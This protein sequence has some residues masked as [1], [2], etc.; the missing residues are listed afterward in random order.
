MG[1]IFCFLVFFWIPPP[2]S[3][4]HISSCPSI[5]SNLLVSLLPD[6]WL[7]S[8]FPSW[9]IPFLGSVETSLFSYTF[10]CPTKSQRVELSAG[11][12]HCTILKG[13]V[14]VVLFFPPRLSILWLQ[15][16]GFSHLFPVPL[17]NPLLI[18]GE[19]KKTTE[20][21]RIIQAYV[22][23]K[24]S[25]ELSILFPVVK[26]DAPWTTV[27]WKPVHSVLSW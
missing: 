9:E 18:N 3:S 6:F 25:P 26:C 27:P 20:I 2:A 21:K 12:F 23:I 5:N 16:T 13:M 22:Q 7:F 14:K 24:D 8:F 1:F 11:I 10:R 4:H 19:P 15:V 17:P